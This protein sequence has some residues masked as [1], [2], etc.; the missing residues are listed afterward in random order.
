MQY[1]LEN[2]PPTTN[3]DGGI[4]GYQLALAL[5]AVSGVA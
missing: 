1:H 4:L 3:P 5:D 2:N